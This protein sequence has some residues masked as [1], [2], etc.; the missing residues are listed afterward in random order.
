MESPGLGVEPDFLE[1][2][3]Q[4]ISPFGPHFHQKSH[5]QGD[6]WASK[7]IFADDNDNLGSFE[8]NLCLDRNSSEVF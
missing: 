6:K 1:M 5:S 8:E 3:P 2:A 7:S 4:R